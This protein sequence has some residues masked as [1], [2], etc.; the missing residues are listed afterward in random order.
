VRFPGRERRGICLNGESRCG[1]A[2]EA[3][4]R[5]SLVDVSHRSRRS[6]ARGAALNRSRATTV[7]ASAEKLIVDYAIG[8]CRAA[9]LALSLS[10]S[11]SLYIYIYIYTPLYIPLYS[12]SEGSLSVPP[13][14]RR[15]PDRRPLLVTSNF[16]K[17]LLSQRP[18]RGNGDL[19]PLGAAIPS[20][21]PEITLR[22]G[23]SCF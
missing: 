8:K 18:E 4:T 1:K 20:D 15:S 9:F 22:A 5:G 10:L 17:R 2:P 13:I 23:R 19:F 3:A 6:A 11:L 21:R 12:L 7:D 16:F 14:N